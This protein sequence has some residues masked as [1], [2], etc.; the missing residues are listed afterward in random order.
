MLWVAVVV[1]VRHAYRQPEP[2]DAHLRTLDDLREKA[3][4]GWRAEGGWTL[5][6]TLTLEKELVLVLML[7][8]TE[9]VLE[10]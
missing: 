7:V 5:T 2:I 3:E 6:L 1:V 8:A 9:W 10:P 4:R